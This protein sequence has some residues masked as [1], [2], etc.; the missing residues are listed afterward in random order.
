[1]SLKTSKKIYILQVYPNLDWLVS[2]TSNLFL[3]IVSPEERS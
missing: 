3:Q 2:E 1:M